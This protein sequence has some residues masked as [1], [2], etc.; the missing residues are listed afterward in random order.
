LWVRRL[1]GISFLLLCPL[2]LVD[3]AVRASGD[4]S[5]RA[6]STRRRQTGTPTFSKE[7]VRIFQQ[8]CQSCHHPGDIAPFSLITYQNARPWARAIREQVL[9]RKMPPWKPIAGCGDFLEVRGLTDD[10]RT[11]IVAWVDGGA[12][13]GNPSDLPPPLTF[14]DG[15]SLGEPDLVLPMAEPYTPPPGRDIYRCFSV[16][17]NMRSDRFV[18]SVEIHPGNRKI[19]HHLIGYFDPNGASA[20]LDAADPG[21]GYTCFG[22]PGFST[23][24]I[25][26]AWA[27]GARGSEEPAGI[28]IKL[29]RQSRVVIQVHYHPGAQP[30]SDQTE[31]GLRF[32][33]QPVK[34]ELLF[35]PLEERGFKIPAGT[36]RFEVTESVF[37]PLNAHLVSIAPH[38]HLLGREIGVEMTRFGG[39]PEC[40]IRIDDWD[41]NWQS[42]Y[43]FKNPVPITLGAQLKLKAVYDNSADNP[44][45]PNSPPREVS[46]G[47]ATTDEMALVILGVTLDAQDLPV[48]SPTITAAAVAPDGSLVVN[49]QGIQQGAELEIQGRVVR[50]TANAEGSAATLFSPEYWHALA[51]PGQ[52]VEVRVLNPDGA[53]SAA[54]PFTR[55]GTALSLTA[56]SAASF[57][58]RPAAPESIVAAFGTRFGNSTLVAQEVPLPT[59]LGGTRVRV[60]GTLAPLFFVSSGQINFLIPPG[61]AAGT[62]VIEVTAADGTVSRGE[63]TIAAT[64][65]SIFTANSS[66]TGAPAAQRTSDGVTYSPVGNSDGTPNEIEAGDFLVL[67]GTGLRRASADLVK[68]TIGG[69]SAPVSYAGAQGAFVGLDQINTQVPTG[70]SGLVDLVVM[71]NG[72]TANVV[73]VKIR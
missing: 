5:R 19:V 42:F 29:N 27:P 15:W 53:R 65:P 57:A 59:E 1:I 43:H 12:P 48:S 44:R 35:V 70:V 68:I 56:V 25:L 41:F 58:A 32:A 50:D 16:P 23:T 45:N 38:M 46:Y 72:E 51:P 31:I 36:K 8:N 6:G 2:L 61:T 30:E 66:G 33:R 13:E 63:L 55:P 52:S 37:S 24:G 7:I 17:V 47:E 73:K 20:A 39:Q 69:V 67:F 4:A 26:T 40:L 11:Q 60:N 14:P 21:P 22:G 18:S 49:G 54:Y 3:V 28:G 9:L 62:A 64:A 10:E 71:V 34:K